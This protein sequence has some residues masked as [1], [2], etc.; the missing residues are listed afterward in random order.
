M[1]IAGT[2][3]S[4]NFWTLS[5]TTCEASS[6]NPSEAV[7]FNVPEDLII[8]K[9]DLPISESVIPDKDGIAFLTPFLIVS[10]EVVELLVVN[11]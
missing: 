5:F 7:I 11:E 6:P 10:V 3:K 2:G 1:L 8:E 9:L 4:E